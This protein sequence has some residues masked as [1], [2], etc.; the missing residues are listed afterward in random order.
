MGHQNLL[1]FLQN[2]LGATLGENEKNSKIFWGQNF[3]QK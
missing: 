2:L 1:G 3:K